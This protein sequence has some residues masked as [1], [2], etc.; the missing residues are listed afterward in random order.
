MALTPR[1]QTTVEKL[2]QVGLGDAAA[3]YRDGCRVIEQREVLEAAT[4]LLAHCAREVESALRQVLRGSFGAPPPATPHS[5][6]TRSL[7]E[8]LGLSAEEEPGKSL[9]KTAAEADRKSSGSAHRDEIRH[10]LTVIGA[11]DLVGQWLWI[12]GFESRDPETGEKAAGLHALAHRSNLGPP[13]PLEQHHFDAWDRFEFIIDRIADRVQANYAT[14]A[15]HIDTL[16]ALNAP[17]KADLKQLLNSLARS[18]A[19]L[20]RFLENMQSG[21]W[22]PM[23]VSASVFSNPPP[24]QSDP[25]KGSFWYPKWVPARALRALAERGWKPEA[26]IASAIKA[27]LA[28]DNQSVIRDLVRAAQH[29]PAD[30]LTEWSSGWLADYLRRL[31]GASLDSYVFSET[32]KLFAYQASSGE[33]EAALELAGALYDLRVGEGWGRRDP[34]PLTG[35]VLMYQQS[36]ERDFL[37]IAELE[38]RSSV[39]LLT[40][41]LN[42]FIS[43]VTDRPAPVDGS[44]SWIDEVGGHAPSEFAEVGSVL[45]AALYTTIHEAIESERLNL[46]ESVDFLLEQGW[47]VFHRCA[48]A[49]T[50][51]FGNPE[52]VAHI[53]EEAAHL[54]DPELEVETVRLLEERF[55]ELPEESKAALLILLE[56]GPSPG[57]WVERAATW[58]EVLT[59]VEA[60]DRARD[61]Q[62]W[63]LG[64]L[65]TVLPAEWVGTHTALFPP[66][67]EAT[68]PAPPLYVKRLATVRKALVEDP[69]EGLAMLTTWEEEPSWPAVSTL[70]FDLGREVAAR[71]VEFATVAD[72]LIGGDATLVR[73]FA[74]KLRLGSE[75]TGSLEDEAVSVWAPVLELFTWAVAQDRAIERRPSNTYNRDGDPHWGWAWKD[76]ARCL[77]VGMRSGVIPRELSGAVWAI[78][79]SLTHDPDKGDVTEGKDDGRDAANRALNSVRGEALDAAITFVWWAHLKKASE[80][81]TTEEVVHHALASLA[82]HLDPNDDTVESISASHAVFGKRLP[83]LIATARDWTLSHL[84][85]LFPAEAEALRAGAWHG[86]RYAQHNYSDVYEALKPYYLG[87]LNGLTDD[88]LYEELI[89]NEVSPEKKRLRPDVNRWVKQI[90]YAYLIGNDDIENTEGGSPTVALFAHASADLRA[91]ALDQVGYL[92]AKRWSVQSQLT[93]ANRAMALWEW[94]LD[95]LGGSNSLVV[96]EGR[97]FS[98]WAFTSALNA[99]WVHEHL[100]L[101]IDASGGTVHHR[102]YR[103]VSWLAETAEAFPESAVTT[104]NMMLGHR[105]SQTYVLHDLQNVEVILHVAAN[106]GGSSRSV[107]KEAISRI[108]AN[109][110]RDFRNLLN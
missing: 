76:I 110:G 60:T 104:M 95:Q 65:Q 44:A 7:L 31:E 86:Y 80:A 58:G 77:D 34:I 13:R 64:K 15:E 89:P 75:V 96:A 78:L 47:N 61:V 41:V 32:G 19:G 36:L 106:A 40:E 71:G 22:I 107:A 35:D 73:A 3:F 63:L 25:D 14:V 70:A 97:S 52:D 91:L 17:T 57:F 87:E 72:R 54:F 90:A 48:I 39:D 93:V 43:Y 20:G 94:R 46:A 74:E 45:A 27:V 102:G 55:D 33:V 88:N 16:A 109:G 5:E 1:Q 100:A 108:L 98:L 21:L 79:D 51:V 84:D 28:T 83:T 103:F 23:L 37:S 9:M 6:S 26:M 30:L 50:R 8:D 81:P 38:P 24:K 29:L 101:A 10:I 68:A 69:A 105:T 18:P 67:V 53:V 66:T 42:R 92:L 56:E 82:R 99:E 12:T 2:K 62:R 59:E 85:R 11:E 4:H 49:L